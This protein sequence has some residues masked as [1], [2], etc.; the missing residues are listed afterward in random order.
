[1]QDV[2]ESLGFNG[3]SPF[4]DWLEELEELD[5][6]DAYDQLHFRLMKAETVA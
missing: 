3:S 1:M 4:V 6:A 5:Q 2:A